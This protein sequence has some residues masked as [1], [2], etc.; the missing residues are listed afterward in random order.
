MSAPAGDLVYLSQAD[1]EATGIGMPEI[2]DAL[3]AAF[4]EKAAGHVEMPPKPGIHPGEGDNFIHAMPASIPALGSVGIKWVSGYPNNKRL[5]LPYISGLLILNDPATGLPIAVMDCVWITAMRTAAASALSARY[6]ARTDSARLAVL[7]CGVQGHSHLEA[8]LVVLPSLRELRAYDVDP[9]RA[10]DLVE[11]AGE[12]YG[13][14]ARAVHDPHEAVDGAD[15]VVTAGP[16]LHVPHATIRGGWLSAG[17][18][19]SAVEFDSYF[20]PEA[21]AEID[22]FTTDDLPQLEQ[23]R[24]M[25]YFQHFPPVHAE[26]ADLVSGRLPGRTSISERT[27]ACNLGLALDDMA[28]APLVLRRARERGLGVTLAR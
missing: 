10:A 1:V 6:L 17:V 13:L 15:V 19:V 16:I 9:A 28:V 11:T 3:E 5:G 7:G 12:R 27:L 2:I 8:L 24:E 20:H 4:R 14:A 22:K 26:L 21:F 25:G 18:F 23:F